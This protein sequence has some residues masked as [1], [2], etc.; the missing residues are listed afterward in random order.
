MADE[1]EGQQAPEGSNQNDEMEQLRR[2]M[3]ELRGQLASKD[4]IIAQERDGRA[5]AETAHMS[6]AERRLLSEEQ[7]CDSALDS[8]ESEA[9]ALEDQIARLADEGGHGKEIAGL[10]RKL[11][12][13]EARKLDTE[14]RKQWLGGQKE[15]AK[16]AA[17][18]PRQTGRVLADGRPLNVFP[19][20]VQGWI[21]KHPEFFSDPRVINKAM[22]AHYRAN[23]EG[24][25]SQGAAYLEFLENETFGNGNRPQTRQPQQSQRQERDDEGDEDDSQP[26]QRAQGGEM[27][28]NVSKPQGDAAGPG[29][30]ARATRQ[31]PGQQTV[32][33]QRR[34][35]ALSRDEK[36]VADSLYA[37]ITDPKER[38]VKYA[39]NKDFM[40][41]YRPSGQAN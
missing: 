31:M 1:T 33:G 7:A 23:A 5:K 17:E 13:L 12:G 38:Y 35:P 37:H 20:E 10:N 29:S 30:I 36:E 34:Q 25:P 27:D 22:A 26:Q 8:I 3:A 39:Q 21:E 9:S 32:N 6:E 28:Y 40:A 2:E 15:Q 19:Q 41:K 14:R 16:R 18:A 11:A 24:I 4:V